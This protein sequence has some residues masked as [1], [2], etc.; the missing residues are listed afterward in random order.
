MINFII[1]LFSFIY[2]EENINL[3]L[4]KAGNKF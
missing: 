4:Y 1:K 2:K 3:Q